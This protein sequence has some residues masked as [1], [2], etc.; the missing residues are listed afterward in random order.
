MHFN[1]YKNQMIGGVMSV[2]LQEV[3][4]HAA[5][6]GREIKIGDKIVY[7][8]GSTGEVKAIERETE[9]S[10]FV[11]SYSVFQGTGK[12]YTGIKIG[13]DTYKPVVMA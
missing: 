7:N 5:K 4:W 6:L 11:S 13:E 10:I 8:Y 3:G 9:K 12:L 1:N 2:W